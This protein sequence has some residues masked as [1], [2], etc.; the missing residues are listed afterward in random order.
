MRFPLSS[1]E[2]GSYARCFEPFRDIYAKNVEETSAES[3]VEKYGDVVLREFDG[4]GVRDSMRPEG[5]DLMVLYGPGYD[6]WID[7]IDGELQ[8]AMARA[9]NRWAAEMRDTSGGRVLAAAPRGLVVGLTGFHH[10]LA[11]SAKRFAAGERPGSA[12]GWRMRNEIPTLLMIGIVVLV[13]IKP[14]S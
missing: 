8:A 1:P 9:Y 13:I 5:I 12:R 14:F 3:L 7:G 11:K 10:Y 2:G 4:P 6:M